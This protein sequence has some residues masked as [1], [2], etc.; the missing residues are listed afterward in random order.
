ML[1]KAIAMLLC[2]ALLVMPLCGM[3]LFTASAATFSA[4][5]V[6][7][8]IAPFDVVAPFETI[9]V[10]YTDAASCDTRLEGTSLG[11]GSTMTF[12]PS[13]CG[14]ADGIYTLMMEYKNASGVTSYETLFFYVDSNAQ[15]GADSDGAAVSTFAVDALD[16]TAGYASSADG[17]IDLD[18]VTDYGAAEQYALR[19]T[20]DTT[21]ASSVSGIPYQVFD[22]DLEGKTSGSVAVHYS[23]A[24]KAGE[25][26]VVKVYNPSTAEWDVVGRFIGEGSVS[27]ELNVAT[28]NHGGV[29]H[30]AAMLDYAF[31][32]SDT[33]I[34]STDPQHYTKFEDLHEYY[35]T[36][37][38]Y[39]AQQYVEGK[40]GY[41]LTT[42]DLVDDRPTA[43]VAPHQWSVSNQAMSYIEAVGMPNG[44]VAGNHD[45][46]DFK[47]TDYSA[48]P[49]TT[50]DYSRFWETYPATRYNQNNW[51]GGSINNNMSHYD[52]VTIGNVDFIIMQLG[53]GMEAT[54]ETIAWANDVL[55]TYR[56]RVAIISTHEY[57]DATSAQRA[58]RGQLIYDKIVDP[59]PNVKLVLCGHDDGSLCVETTASDGRTVYEIL[60]DYQFVEAEEPEFYANEHWI[61]SVPE[62]CG[63]G[64]LRLMT[65]EGETLRSITYSPVTGRYNP[66]GDRENLLLD[67]DC[68]D[69][70]RF[71]STTRFS[72]AVRQSAT[73]ATNVD[74]MAVYTNGNVTSFGA[75]EYASVPTAPASADAVEWPATDFGAA[76]TPS[77]PYY[78]HAA[79]EAPVVD[80]KVD[81][82]EKAGLGAHPSVKGYT[83]VGNSSL[84]IKI[85]LN[86]TPY[87]YYSFAVPAG[88]SFT[89]SFFNNSNYSPWL[90]FL[91]ATKG[92]TTMNKDIANW[93]AYGS[94]GN[95]YF[96]T[97]A[98]GC[99]DMRTLSKDGA[100]WIVNQL[101]VYNS[102]GSAVTVSY[103][104]FGSAPSA[105][106]WPDVAYG[107][108]A[109]PASP[110]HQH[111]AKEAPRVEYKVDMM[112][113]AGFTS[114]PAVSES[115][116][117]AA[118]ATIDLSKTPYLY[119][120]FAV[121][122]GGH[123]TFGFTNNSNYCPWLTFLDHEVGG[124][125]FAGGTDFWNSRAGAQYHQTSATGCIDMRQITKDPY[126]LTLVITQL[127][128]Y[129]YRDVQ[130]V[131]SY[132][133]FGS[134]ALGADG[135]VSADAAALTDLIAKANKLDTAGYPDAS[136]TAFKNAR[137]A[138]TLADLSDDAAVMKAYHALST[139][140]GALE[141]PEATIDE[142][143][144]VSVKNF[145]MTSANW[146]CNT[147]GSAL[148]EGKSYLDITQH[149]TGMTLSY[150]ERATHVWPHARY[151]GT[152]PSF[153]VN[154]YGGVYAKVD[155]DCPAGWAISMAVT[156]DGVTQTMRINCAGIENG[157]NAPGFDGMQGRFNGIYDIS[158]AFVQYGFD[159]TA[160]FTV[161]NTY[162]FVLGGSGAK[163]RYNHFELFTGK[164]T[165][166]S[167]TKL[168]SDITYAKLRQ[169]YKYTSASWSTF[170][171]ALDNA[172]TKAGMSGLTQPAIELARHQLRKA[173]EALVV[174]NPVEPQGSLI[175]EDN[176]LWVP[177]QSGAAVAWRNTDMQTIVS[178]ENGTYAQATYMLAE[179]I[180][181]R[182]KD[183][184][185]V[186]DFNTL[187][188]TN[189]MVL[190]DGE[191][192]SLSP[193]ITANRDGED[194]RAGEY[195]AEIPFS[196]IAQ[197]ADKA[198]VV[199][200]G[201]R[202]WSI[203]AVG[204]NAVVLRDFRID[205]YCEHTFPDGVTYG[206]AATDVNTYYTHAAKN[207]PL[208][209]KKV[210]VLAALGL[211]HPVING[212][213]SYGNNILKLTVD[214]NET[215]Y[216]YYSFALSDNANFTFSFINNTTYAPWLTFLDATKGATTMNNG[217]DVW[218]SMGGAQYFN[219]SVTG[220]IDM[221]TLTTDAATQWVINT[222]SFYNTKGG[223][224]TVSY[225]FFGS[226]TLRDNYIEDE[227][228]DLLMGDVNGDGAATTLDARAIL[229]YVLGVETFDAKQ[230]D[231]A[232]MNG[233]GVITTADARD[234]LLQIVNNA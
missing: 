186:I 162:L 56:H 179:P 72:A 5:G 152:S 218:D 146:V 215:P 106:V 159:P 128:L 79:K 1:K 115:A 65:V 151:V 66:Y 17:T 158:E 10:T 77:N 154:P 165:T 129:N 73:T 104:F 16:F 219:G 168:N 131:V 208:T 12:S 60:S 171:T 148:G 94:N 49:N 40:A 4:P 35:Y 96:R 203:G 123:F 6:S 214:L 232:D 54:D 213:T 198:A 32:G 89:F 183:N 130:P 14:L 110:Y 82:L 83:T 69:P 114:A 36:M 155:V 184:A 172:V 84:G 62:C 19:Y 58:G 121:P 42:G 92:G 108:A 68:G 207:A 87:L 173:S 11:T 169:Q 50:S 48:G 224:A 141:L 38:Q 55:A 135:G 227:E 117:Y 37:Y 51:Y 182:V 3:T 197:C 195:R 90:T 33:M 47:P 22:I 190:I 2:A 29:V 67:L 26:M 105:T 156:Q 41:I 202:V 216:L 45:V 201:I 222:V 127:R 163:V 93:D 70:E 85:N 134:E 112:E 212:W 21:G 31:N 231:L 120:S 221:R 205:T 161:S 86:E 118:S 18:D 234:L 25:R 177:N 174:A 63:D 97:S 230:I 233:D 153:T 80:K 133:F 101:N 24:T 103:L 137:T 119:Y 144:L 139:A 75:V 64:Y 138:A 109:T 74:R 107:Q 57:L 228:E 147:T 78:A 178:N 52:L 59:N 167:Y 43:S 76:A 170:K 15:Q 122:E 223:D 39:A 124:T 8:S 226:E 100:N 192:V 209:A 164:T 27:K 44:L 20:A 189:P 150:S 91:D 99:I 160:T 98:T 200:E 185:F 143:S 180:R 142:S 34:W 13:S 102:V 23:G 125:K 145:P 28:Y 7:V 81:V 149:S 140:M 116:T 196:R 176:T 71:F 9:T 136:V 95:Q 193:Y 61:G 206:P 113:I 111:A 211:E 225:L 194:I 126:G 30:V 199:I 53:Y 210:D 88:G 187:G 166:A 217:S 188:G 220:C 181:V 204:A 132:L 157:F 191:W 175:P 229:Y 46:A